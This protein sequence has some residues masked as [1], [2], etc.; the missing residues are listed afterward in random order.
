MFHFF[1]KVESIS[2]AELEKRLKTNIKLLDVRTPSEYN[3]GHIKGALNIP[4]GQIDRYSQSKEEELYVICHS[5]VR[6]RLAAKKLKKKG[7]DV[8]NVS[9]GMMS[10]K[11][12]V[13]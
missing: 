4:L 9:G 5:G 12:D 6:S 7:Y 10:W 2:T 13:V 3:R 8:V 11:G 1:T